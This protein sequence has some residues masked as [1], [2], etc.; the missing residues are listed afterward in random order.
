MSKKTSIETLLNLAKTLKQTRDER[1]Q[2]ESLDKT[3]TN[4]LIRVMQDD[5]TSEIPGVV[6]LTTVNGSKT[7]YRVLFETLAIEVGMTVADMQ[8]RVNSATTP[9]SYSKLVFDRGYSG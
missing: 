5:D 2:W 1:K 6:T 3:Q 8:A 4:E 7:D 9:T